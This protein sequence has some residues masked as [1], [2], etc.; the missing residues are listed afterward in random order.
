MYLIYTGVSNVLPALVGSVIIS[1][2]RVANETLA[3][4][5]QFKPRYLKI[6]KQQAKLF[7]ERWQAVS[8]IE[9]EEEKAASFEQ[10]WQQLNDI[11]R[12]A[13]GLRLSLQS[14]ESEVTVYYR[15]ARLKESAL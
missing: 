13:R 10:R 5:K 9:Q 2:K 12:L 6:D 7:R 3:M 15:W 1:Y 11:I 14:D 4:R 8:Q